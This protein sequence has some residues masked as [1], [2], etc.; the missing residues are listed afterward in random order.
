[1]FPAALSQLSATRPFWQY[2]SQ[3]HPAANL[4]HFR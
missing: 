4:R 1:M 3:L 2:E